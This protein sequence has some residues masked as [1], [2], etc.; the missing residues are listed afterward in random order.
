[1][2]RPGWD[3]FRAGGD[4]HQHLSVLRALDQGSQQLEAGR[5]DGRLPVAA[6]CGERRNSDCK[7]DALR[8]NQRMS[9]VP[10][11]LSVTIVWEA[12]YLPA[13]GL[14]EIKGEIPAGPLRESWD[15]FFH[16][17]VAGNNPAGKGSDRWAAATLVRASREGGID[18]QFDSAAPTF[19]T[20]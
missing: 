11:W 1:M 13:L 7:R 12:I 9:R 14:F 2:V 19:E 5:L 4:E 10:A 20:E 15:S 3:E 18:S 16:A 6:D 8:D 17:G